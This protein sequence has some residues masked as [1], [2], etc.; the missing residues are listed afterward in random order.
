MP[1]K[2]CF[3]NKVTKVAAISEDLDR[4]LCLENRQVS[5]YS[6]EIKIRAGVGCWSGVEHHGPSSHSV[7]RLI[8]ITVETN[9]HSS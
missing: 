9:N 2:T 6:I 4:Y 1:A 7:L 5:H 3:P 8:F